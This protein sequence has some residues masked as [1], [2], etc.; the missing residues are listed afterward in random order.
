MTPIYL[1]HASTTPLDPAVLE[2]M[3]P[4]LTR[5]H[6][7]PSSLHA[8]G[9]TARKG[10]ERAREQVAAVMGVRPRQLVFTSG[11]TE[12]DNLAIRGLADKRPGRIVSSR[13]EHA[14][15]LNTVMALAAAGRT[16]EF[17]PPDA[18]GAIRPEALERLTA[19][20]D[21]PL[22]LVALMQVNNETGAITDVAAIARVAHRAGAVFV[23]D[24]VQATGLE[25]V[26]LAASGA[27]V[28]T[29][30]AHKINGPKGVGALVRADGLELEPQF[31]GGSQERGLR[32]GTHAVSAIVGFGAALE[33]A[34]ERRQAHRAHLATVQ[35]ELERACLSVPG[36]TLNAA[37]AARGV[38][39]S[40][41]SVEGVDGES[42]LMALD[43]AGVQVSAGSA[44]AAGSL[45]PSHV[46]LAMGLSPARARASVRYS[47]GA[48]TT[49]AD[50]REAASSSAPSRSA[51]PDTGA[52]NVSRAAA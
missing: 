38:K 30:S 43:D 8:A 33:L 20:A 36:V 17:V 26:S 45:E 9:R 13:L 11:A 37:G 4:Y 3:M 2:A 12:A 10:I 51:A 46:L 6:G 44:C 7:N 15:V 19:A 42:L 34:A 29:L 41:F 31:A 49:L 21:Q 48:Q 5:V 39:H 52:G 25:D 40:N 1:D 50:V 22:A 27:D 18:A 35:A 47:Y 32:P 23:C 16:V 24:A 28:V 14:A